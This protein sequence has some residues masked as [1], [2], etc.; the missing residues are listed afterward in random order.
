[1][2]TKKKGGEGMQLLTKELRKKLP[3][4]YSQ[5]NEIDPIVYVKYFDP[6]GFWTWYVTE[7]EQRGD[8]FLFFG[9]VIG[10][11]EELGYFTLSQLVTTK[12][13]AKGLQAMPIERD[14]YFA[15]CRLSKVK[16]QHNRERGTRI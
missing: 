2:N 16:E 13:G 11:E 3:R 14:I 9:L 12:V 5:E 7:G 1:M 6:V 10:F 4:L 8:D 15:L